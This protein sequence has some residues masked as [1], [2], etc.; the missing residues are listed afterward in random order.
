[1][2]RTGLERAGIC[3]RRSTIHSSPCGTMRTPGDGDG[4]KDRGRQRRN[5]AFISMWNSSRLADFNGN[6]LDGTTFDLL[7]GSDRVVGLGNHSSEPSSGR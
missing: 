6:C 7:A 1:M 5:P 2:Y 4:D 3:S